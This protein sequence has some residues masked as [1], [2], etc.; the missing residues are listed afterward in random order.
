M[1]VGDHQEPTASFLPLLTSVSLV[2]LQVC[3]HQF[4]RIW[5]LWTSKM[6]SSNF[7]ASP[8]LESGG[9]GIEPGDQLAPGLV[10]VNCARQIVPLKFA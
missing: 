2:T 10:A 8:W 1:S 5:R 7:D 6:A 3:P 9:H 4:A